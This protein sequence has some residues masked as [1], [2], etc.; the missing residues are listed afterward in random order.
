MAP[1]DKG[2]HLGDEIHVDAALIVEAARRVHGTLRE[3]E[4]GG[5]V[6][7]RELGHV[8]QTV[9][10][11]H[12]ARLGSAVGEGAHA[13]RAKFCLVL[14][15]LRTDGVDGLVPADALPLT[16]ATLGALGA[17]HGVLDALLLHDERGDGGAAG[18]HALLINGRPL[19]LL[20]ARE[21]HVAV[22]HNR[23]QRTTHAGVA[24]GRT[25]FL[26]ALGRSRLG[27]KGR[28]PGSR[29]AT[30]NE[31]SR[32]RGLEEPSSRQ[33]SRCVPNR[34]QDVPF[35]RLVCPSAMLTGILW[36]H[37]EIERGLRG[38]SL[39]CS[40]G[41]FGLRRSS[42]RYGDETLSVLPEDEILFAFFAMVQ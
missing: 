16:G 36:P 27:R 9:E 35:P 30:R 42:L 15:D 25:D 28:E 23:F 37:S 29:S 26:V 19:D 38:E 17:L 39:G 14:L 24:V 11:V 5:A 33:S 20:R 10:I 22:A 41:A 2:A 32:G 8:L 4:V 1:H 40:L 18:A 3:R 7:V 13:A 6:L 21:H 12:V 31:R 34:L